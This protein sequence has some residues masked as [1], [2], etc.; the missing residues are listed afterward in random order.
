M[1]IKGSLT[2]NSREEKGVGESVG[3]EVGVEVA[4]GIELKLKQN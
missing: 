4:V 3:K 2:R 1:I